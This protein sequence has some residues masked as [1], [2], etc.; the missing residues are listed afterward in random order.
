MAKK[1]SGCAPQPTVCAARG[2]VAV[3]TGSKNAASR[4]RAKHWGGG[5][6]RASKA[7]R[8]SSARVIISYLEFRL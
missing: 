1:R 8:L 3:Y 4:K 6:A 7:I 2:Q 5:G